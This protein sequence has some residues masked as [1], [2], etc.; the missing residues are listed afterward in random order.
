[1]IKAGETKVTY[2]PVELDEVDLEENS[3]IK[4]TLVYGSEQEILLKAISQ[5]FVFEVLRTGL[6][7]MIW[8]IIML[9]VL[10][11]VGAIV[12]FIM[13]KSSGGSSRSR[14]RRY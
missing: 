10:L 6:G 12:F 14:R 5:N 9:V 7:L 2:I 1:M 8:I 4:V 11:A 3:E 13:K